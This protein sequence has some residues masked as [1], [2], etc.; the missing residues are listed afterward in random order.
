MKYE[1]LSRD[2]KIRLIKSFTDILMK[3]ENI[4]VFGLNFTCKTDAELDA[5]L[6]GVV[7]LMETIEENK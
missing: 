1:L 4:A 3:E 6:A 7:A 2:T 5:I